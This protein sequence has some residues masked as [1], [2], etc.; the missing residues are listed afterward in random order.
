[1]VKFCLAD[2][3]GEIARRLDVLRR[4]PYIGGACAA[5]SERE[6]LTFSD[7]LVAFSGVLPT[8]ARCGSGLQNKTRLG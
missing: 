8:S 3:V 7:Y 4:Q 2:L 6:V 1:M 5:N